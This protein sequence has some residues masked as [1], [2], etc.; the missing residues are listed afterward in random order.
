[1][2]GPNALPRNDWFQVFIWE[3]EDLR[4]PQSPGMVEETPYRSK[5]I[6]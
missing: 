1:M 5:S 6:P 3:L 2:N 4:G